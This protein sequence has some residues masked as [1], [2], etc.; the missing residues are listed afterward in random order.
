MLWFITIGYN[1]HGNNLIREI[2]SKIAID[3]LPGANITSP[4]S[5]P[6]CFALLYVAAYEYI[7]ASRGYFMFR[8]RGHQG[9]WYL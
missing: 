9:P 7:S 4:D 3:L 6:S 5:P 1:Y 8:A 2:G